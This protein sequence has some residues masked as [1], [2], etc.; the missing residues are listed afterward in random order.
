MMEK[1]MV[2]KA[3]DLTPKDPDFVT[4]IQRGVKVLSV[5][6]RENPELTL[7]EVADRCGLSPATARRF[8]L[9]FKALG[10]VGANG[11]K[12]VLRPKILELAY[13]YLNSMNVDE[14]LQPYLR[15]IV[16]QTGDSS[17]VTVLEGTDIVYIANASVRRLVR[18]SAGVG[19][20]F[21]AYATSMGRVL[22]AHRSPAHLE[23]YFRRANL[24]KITDF[25]ETDPARLRQILTEVKTNGYA[26]VQDELEVGLVAIAVPIWGPA[27]NVIAAM[28]CSSVARRTDSE[29]I[30]RTRLDLL[31]QFAQQVS[32]ALA[33]FPSLAHS[34]ASEEIAAP[35]EA[36]DPTLTR[37][38]I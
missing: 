27:G 2:R 17:S 13:A 15:E 22:L 37:A 4:S 25:T 21:P 32:A 11:R 34:V 31:K 23:N 14:A 10:Y 12:Y 36:E 29:E 33:R 38:A 1:S 19:S 35:A 26:V 18:L 8:L 7:K 28:N 9:T 16:Q 20:R 6:D 24:H 30:L 3:K 5:F